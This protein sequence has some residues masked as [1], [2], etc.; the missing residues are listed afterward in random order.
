MRRS[1]RGLRRA[2][3]PPFAKLGV[4]PDALSTTS[5]HFN[6]VLPIALMDPRKKL[7][8][9]V[10]FKGGA[11]LKTGSLPS[12]WC[13]VKP[14]P[15]CPRPPSLSNGKEETGHE[16][17][18]ATT[19]THTG[20]CRRVLALPCRQLAL[21]FSSPSLGGRWGQIESSAASRRRAKG[22][23]ISFYQEKKRTG[24]R[25]QPFLKDPSL[26]RCNGTSNSYTRTRI[27]KGQGRPEC[28]CI[29]KIPRSSR[30]AT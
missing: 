2:P 27:E 19:T 25:K 10:L 24:T 26:C 18:H 29:T 4:S 14:T 30:K 8:G 7:E 11:R 23:L 3:F 28:H 21:L 17:N 1:S 15:V 20:L 9:K 22:Y 16:R 5:K 6:L 12:L 13:G